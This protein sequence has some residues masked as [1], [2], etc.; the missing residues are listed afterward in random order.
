M[1]GATTLVP[2]GASSVSVLLEDE[3]TWRLPGLFVGLWD[4]AISKN[5]EEDDDGLE[6]V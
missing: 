6:V 2:T 4:E 5:A 1:I 3:I